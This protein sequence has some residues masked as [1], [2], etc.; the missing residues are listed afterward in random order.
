[1]IWFCLTAL[2]VAVLLGLVGLFVWALGWV[3]HTLSAVLVPM[4]FALILAYILD[5]VVGY[6]ERK[7]L[8]RLWSV[9]LVFVLAML[10]VVAVIG[11]ILPDLSRESHKLIEDFPRISESIQGKISHFLND[12]A[13]GRQLPASWRETFQQ[14]AGKSH[15]ARP[16]EEPELRA[17]TSSETNFTI[18]LRPLFGISVH[19]GTNSAEVSTN[20]NNPEPEQEMNGTKIILSGLLSLVK[21]FNFQLHRISTWVEFIIGFVLVPVYLFYFLLEKEPITR[22]WTD[23]LPMKSGRAKD[24]LIFVLEAINDCMIVFFRGQVLV[25]LCVGVLLAVGYALLGLNYAILLGLVAATLGIVPYLGTITSLILALTVAA[26][27]FQDWSHPL[28]VLCIAGIV[29]LLEDFLIGPRIIG[30]RAGLHP[31]TIILA[32][33]IGTTLLGGFI[34]AM[35]AIPLT[36]ALRTLMFRYIWIKDQQ[37]AQHQA[38]ELQSP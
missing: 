36:A 24:E 23:Y 21:K 4:A 25:A 3:F 30:E 13:I 29:K 19:T 37:S 32:V 11:S 2:A 15:N 9:T 8:P 20:A 12:S 33:M 10:L 35:L 6:F 7:R 16:S 5:P 38:S 31:L 14:G 28:L 1:M 26:I 17:P 34:G 18:D 22:H 27:Q